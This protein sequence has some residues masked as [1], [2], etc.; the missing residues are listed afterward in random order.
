MPSTSTQ[1]RGGPPD[2]PPPGDVLGEGLG[3]ELEELGQGL[4][5]EPGVGAPDGG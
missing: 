2:D 3:E 1:T 4:G 5:E